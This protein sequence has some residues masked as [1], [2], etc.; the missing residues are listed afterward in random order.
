MIMVSA[1][2]PTASKELGTESDINKKNIDMRNKDK[3]YKLLIFVCIGIIA[4]LL[5]IV[6]I[7]SVRA[8]MSL[9]SDTST[10]H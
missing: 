7:L 2:A 1:A 10:S 3:E 9:N 5:F 6:L 4:L 8:L